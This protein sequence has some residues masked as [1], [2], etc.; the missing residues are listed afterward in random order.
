MTNL[1][2]IQILT[3]LLLAIV[4]GGTIGYEREQ[5]NRPAGM[6]THILVCLGA[7]IIALIQQELSL[8]ALEMVKNDPNLANVV[9]FDQSRLIAQVISGIG[10]LGAGTIII[11]KQRV[12]GLTTAASL[13]SVAAIGIGIGMGFYV[14]TLFSFL[15]IMFS[16]SLVKRIVTISKVNNLEIQYVH[17][18][19]TKNFIHE[20]FESRH[21]NIED[22]T[23]EVQ[24]IDDEKFY[25][26][27]YTID[28]PKELTY[29]EVIEDLSMYS[30]VREIRLV[31][32]ND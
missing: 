31:S 30:N 4:M 25:K 24:K 9:K 20:Y 23:F 18:T 5:K 2:I 27:I 3:R 19:E 8:D 14:V 7:T 10:F 12:T 26:N 28:L 1:S 21:I 22:V 6:K 13:W 17:R 11:T 32:V 29:A 15:A 16:L